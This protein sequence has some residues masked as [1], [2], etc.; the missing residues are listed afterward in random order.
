MPFFGVESSSRDP[1][2]AQKGLGLVL[3]HCFHH[4]VLSQQIP[5]CVRGGPASP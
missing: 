5:S 2:G 3:S 4:E 1:P